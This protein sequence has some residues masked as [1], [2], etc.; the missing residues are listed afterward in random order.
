MEVSI[1]L[2][3]DFTALDVFGPVEV[4]TVSEYTLAYYSPQG[5]LVANHQ[6]IEIMTRPWTEIPPGNILLLPGGYGTRRAVQDES[7]IAGLAR[8]AEAAQYCLTVCTGSALL[9]Q[10]GLLNGRKAT[11]NKKSLDWVRGFGRDVQWDA[12][13]RYVVDGKYYTSSGVS[14]GIDMALAFAADRLGQQRAEEIRRRME[15][16]G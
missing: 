7:F 14:A 1:V 5:G 13:A 3:D 11:S 16:Q 12:T 15:Y 4:L 2:F 10:T 9:A 6:G 8:L